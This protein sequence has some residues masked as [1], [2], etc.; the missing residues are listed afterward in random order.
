MNKRSKV[1]GIGLSKTATTSL[2]RAM[3][4]L[5]FSVC[6]YS[7]C[8]AN[9]ERKDFA[10]DLLVVTTYKWLDRRFPGSKF[11]YTVREKEKWLNSCERHFANLRWGDNLR[12]GVYG[13]PVFDRG[14][15]WD[16]Y[17]RHDADVREYFADRP[18]DL[19][20]IDITA[21]AGWKQICDFVGAEIPDTPFPRAN[22]GGSWTGL[23][24]A[25]LR[26]LWRELIQ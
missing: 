18:G 20:I 2:A 24:P 23:I 8:F 7:E 17:C 13:A 12:L 10:R 15:F 19:L 16:A 22:P 21:G 3:H 1:F 5:G 4:M 11:V 6:S 25:R 26:N 14:L 9:I